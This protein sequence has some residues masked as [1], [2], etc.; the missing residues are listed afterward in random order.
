MTSLQILVAL[1]AVSAALSAVM[2][3]AWLVEQRTGNSGW[4]DTVW[5]F[6]LGAVG[7]VA[8]LTPT[9]SMTG[10][11]ARQQIVAALLGIWSLRLGAHIAR[12]TA[13]I[14]DDPRYAK[15]RKDWGAA[16]ARWQMW[17]LLQKQAL[18]SIPMAMA[19]FVAAHNPLPLRF[20]DSVAIVVLL[21]GIGGEML[22]DRQLR[23]FASKPGNKG[24]I[25]DS[26]L[27]AWSRHPNYFFEWYGW[28]AYPLFAV[29]FSGAYPWGWIAVAAPLCMY[30]LL[31]HVSGIPPLE[32]HMLKTRGDKFRAYQRRTSAFF[33]MPPKAST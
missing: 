12:R 32:E 7:I 31:V 9:S 13:G 3:L 14:K 10:L 21:I 19:V 8:A 22:S 26:G 1:L 15:L 25:C 20:Q 5:T 27:W 18:V 2:T 24:K 23:R 16:Q 28:L 33:P 29:D 11:T 6:G 17:L 30:W 4:I